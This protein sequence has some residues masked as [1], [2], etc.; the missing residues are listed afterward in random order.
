MDFV[1]KNDLTTFRFQY[2]GRSLTVSLFGTLF[3]TIAC[4]YLLTPIF[5]LNGVWL[6]PTVSAIASGILTA[7]L[8]LSMRIT[9]NDV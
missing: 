8:A 2:R 9:R 3:F 1:T 7:I 6:M 4:P 5:G